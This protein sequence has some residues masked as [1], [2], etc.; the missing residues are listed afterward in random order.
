MKN[1]IKRIT[2]NPDNLLIQKSI[3][4]ISFLTFIFLFV[5]F[6]LFGAKTY[7]L[8]I[9]VIGRDSNL[10]IENARIV[11]T[12]NDVK[13]EVGVTNKN[14][15]FVLSGLTEK[16]IDIKV[17]SQTE[18]Y[19]DNFLNFF[20]PKRV[21]QEETIYLRSTYL[22]EKRAYELIDSSYG[23]EKSEISEYEKDSIN[24]KMP[25]PKE[26]MDA[27]RKFIN[28]HIEYPQESVEMGESGLVIV[29]FVIQA[30][31][32]VTHV[33]VKKG[34][35]IYLDEEAIRIIRK[36]NKWNAATYKG[37]PIKSHVQIPITFSLN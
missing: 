19:R 28:Q 23:Q 9:K 10:P 8:T 22:K 12:I 11:T 34:A 7:T 31:G 30:D 5:G 13:K 20:N 17:I 36:S 1:Q 16:E 21:D 26:G 25:E 29:S 15:E 18:N 27:F 3:M 33:K 37:K 14:G 2:I 32:Q 4:K 6:Q 35:S 24:F